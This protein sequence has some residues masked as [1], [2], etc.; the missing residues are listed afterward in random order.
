MCKGHLLR[1][2]F[3]EW[4]LLV[5]SR[6]SVLKFVVWD[7]WI[8]F[9]QLAYSPSPS[10]ALQI[11]ATQH[12]VIPNWAV[13]GQ[14]LGCLWLDQ[15]I[16]LLTLPSQWMTLHNIGKAAW[17]SLLLCTRACLVLVPWLN[18]ST[19]VSVTSRGGKKNKIWVNKGH[20]CQI[21]LTLVKQ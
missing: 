21:Q 1:Y 6:N 16:Y 10:Q 19:S 12:R 5:F 2:S 17:E 15:M 4:P 9:P 13:E 20:W 8:S 18:R 11:A 14:S 3:I 7:S